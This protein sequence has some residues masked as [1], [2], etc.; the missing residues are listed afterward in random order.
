[1]KPNWKTIKDRG[2]P[3][4]ENQAQPVRGGQAPD[5]LLGPTMISGLQDVLP[6]MAPAEPADTGGM[7]IN[8]T[9]VLP[10]QSAAEQGWT[11]AERADVP[12]GGQPDNFFD[13]EEERREG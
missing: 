10:P 2:A 8:P 6:G 9:V 1:M 11:G 4:P 12:A 7:A 5:G 3:E 13:A